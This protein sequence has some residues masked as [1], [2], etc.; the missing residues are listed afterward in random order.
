MEEE[1]RAVANELADGCKVEI[2]SDPAGRTQRGLGFDPAS[3]AILVG[4]YVLKLAGLAAQGAVVKIVSELVYKRLKG[5][6]EVKTARIRFPD[7]TI[8]DLVLDDPKSQEGL[9]RLIAMKANA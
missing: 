1:L 8:Y 6:N 3:G 4:W 9:E 5:K 7:G 2:T